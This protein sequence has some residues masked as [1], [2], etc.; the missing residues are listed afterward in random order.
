M[1][2]GMTSREMSEWQAYD[3]IEPFGQE[4]DDRSRAII[5]HVIAET[6]RDHKKQ[7]KPSPLSDWMPYPN[8]RPEPEEEP[9]PQTE[10]Y[11]KSQA[12]MMQQLDGKLKRPRA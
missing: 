10:E 1:L 8:G 9:S 12:R 7:S 5:A 3:R 11:Q 4:R 6:H 2:R